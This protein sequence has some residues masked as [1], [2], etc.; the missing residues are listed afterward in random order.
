[1]SSGTFIKIS[2][3]QREIYLVLHFQANSRSKRKKTLI[4][5]PESNVGD[6]WDFDADPDQHL[7]LTDPN[8]N[9][10]PDPTPFFSDLNDICFL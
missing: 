8:P 1:M 2:Q 7:W 3:D 10:T 5:I 9:Q 6:P 4:K